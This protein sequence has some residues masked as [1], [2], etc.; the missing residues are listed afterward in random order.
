MTLKRLTYQ[1]T[2]R[3]P[4]YIPTT[5]HVRTRADARRWTDRDILVAVLVG[6]LTAL[7]ITTTIALVM[8]ATL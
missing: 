2:Q 8:L 4:T 5:A 1:N 7:F 3:Y 6:A